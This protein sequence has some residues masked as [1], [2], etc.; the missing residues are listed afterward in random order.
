MQ[1]THV[2]CPS[3]WSMRAYFALA[4]EP[5]AASAAATA[6]SALALA[7]GS[8]SAPAGPAG[9]APTSTAAV[10][11]ASAG[12]ATAPPGDAL[13]LL[14]MGLVKALRGDP[15]SALAAYSAALIANPALPAAVRVSIGLCHYALK[16]YTA[17]RRAFMRALQLDPK[18]ADAAAALGL[19]ELQLF[20]H[21]PPATAAA[22]SAGADAAA[23]GDPAKALSLLAYAQSLAP[24]HP[25]AL[26]ALANH[27]FFAARTR[28]RL[29]AGS[30][31]VAVS[32]EGAVTVTLPTS[33]AAGIEALLARAEATASGALGG[34]S[35]I[36]VEALRAEIAYQRARVAHSLAGLA[37]PDQPSVAAAAVL[38]TAAEAEAGAGAA[39][40]AMGDVDSVFGSSSAAGVNVAATGEVLAS[41]VRLY[42]FLFA[43]LTFC[44]VSFLKVKC[45]HYFITQRLISHYFLPLNSPQALSLYSAALRLAPAH[46]GALLGLGKLLLRSAL[47]SPSTAT[48][49]GR[50]AVAALTR[51]AAAAPAGEPSVALALGHALLTVGADPARARPL[52]ATA[53]SAL[54]SGAL[55]PLAAA[56]DNNGNKS[57]GTSAVRALDKAEALVLAEHAQACATAAV[58]GG[59][60]APAAALASIARAV[61][62]LTGVS[63]ATLT[64]NP[65]NADSAAD[66]TAAAAAVVTEAAVAAAP[67]ALWHNLGAA[68]HELGS[69][70]DAAAAAYSYSLQQLRR[71]LSPTAASP[72]SSS[73]APT[74]TAAT[75]GPTEAE[76]AAALSDPAATGADSGSTLISS[77][78]SSSLT[79]AGISLPL[80]LPAA[81]VTTAYNVALLLEQ[82]GKTTEAELVLAALVRSHS[83]YTDAVVKLAE[84][85]TRHSL[86]GLEWGLN[87]LRALVNLPPSS[88]TNTANTNANAKPMTDGEAASAAGA[89]V[90]ATADP[91]VAAAAVGAGVVEA[92]AAVRPVTGQEARAQVL[93]ILGELSF[94]NK[95]RNAALLSRAE[96]L[97]EVAYREQ[98]THSGTSSAMTDADSAAPGAGASGA[99]LKD[100]YAIT[101]KGRLLA[102]RG[103]NERV[104]AARLVELRQLRPSSSSKPEL[105]KA[106]ATHLATAKSD[107][108]DA[109]SKFN[110]ALTLDPGCLPAL[111]GLTA[112]MAELAQVDEA[113]AGLPAGTG[114]T[115]AV[116]PLVRAAL[117][118]ARA[119]VPGDANVAVNL[120]HVL[121]Q[122][123][124][125]ADAILLYSAAIATL[126]ATGAG[127]EAVANAQLYLARTYHLASRASDARRALARALEL[128]PGKHSLWYNMA[129]TLEEA[130]V[131]AQAGVTS[132]A[133]TV[134]MVDVASVEAALADATLAR[135]MFA[136]LI[137]AA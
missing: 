12:S 99:A 52:L 13:A 84:L 48:T 42:V 128:T 79:V 91:A 65:N 85:A 83:G 30:P 119:A 101:A 115:R 93:S 111:L 19:L 121:T 3:V 97:Y 78:P 15:R 28:A 113:A 90:A 38:A 20:L 35:A 21:P 44:L 92:F 26:A 96:R 103:S 68:L 126:E 18:C 129:I 69:A 33:A 39:G 62:L 2:N 22:G 104:K 40:A 89:G 60:A 130:S 14:L 108:G 80:P 46:P 37:L 77:L 16:A 1:A 45:K 31:Q 118:D 102:A 110:R 133:V 87:Q 61:S 59:A 72:A 124:Q 51:A 86:L 135:S 117:A 47:S 76:M 134:G 11:L 109:V 132:A 8:A 82:A 81:A 74:V 106:V 50:A 56:S 5:T 64:S 75:A 127:I 125:Y 71:E 98:A 95:H 36:G 73:A 57:E 122:E 70:P 43:M 67:R 114:K 25:L 53:A 34:F 66:A 63:V 54:A 116:L 94:D 9:G 105:D 88:L 123:G 29:Q 55:A 4:A 23:T 112:A 6:E 131:A 7:L 120:A 107:L 137:K 32:S 49:T 17:A 58:T 24:N 41:Q 100:A 27:A 10:A 136:Q